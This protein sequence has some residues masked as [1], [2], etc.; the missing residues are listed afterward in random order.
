MER[1][2]SREDIVVVDTVG[3]NSYGDILF[4][5]KSGTEYK[6]SN[7]RVKYFEGII[8][9]GKA[10]K[11]SFALSSRGTEYVQKAT[12]VEGA[13]PETV[14]TST[15]KPLPT[16]TPAPQVE[17]SGAEMGMTIKEVRELYTMGKLNQLFGPEIAASLMAWYRG[18]ILSTSRIPYDGKDLPPAKG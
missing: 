16:A 3:S 10:V 5:D 1:Q 11:L 13:L 18:R 12:L 6:I 17:I 2:I 8:V 7:K 14:V 4:T 9:A 15:P